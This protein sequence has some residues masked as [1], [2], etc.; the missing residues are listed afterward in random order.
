MNK[1]NLKMAYVGVL[2]SQPSLP[3]Y[4]ST[5]KYFNKYL[6]TLGEPTAAP[7]WN[8]LSI[9]KHAENIIV[10]EKIHNGA[11]LKIDSGGFQIITGKITQN[12]ILEYIECYHLV[13]EKYHKEI[14]KIFSLDINNFTMNAD[15]ILEW[16][17]KST[18]MTIESIKKYPILKEKVLFVLQNRNRRVF[19]IWRKLFI[20]KKVWEHFELFSLGGLVGL[21]KDTKVDFNHAVPAT[22]WLLTY[23]KKY[24]FE[25]KQ[26][27]WLGQSS[28]VVF[29]AMALLEKLYGIYFTSDSSELIRF[30]PIAQ[31]LPLI[32]KIVAYN[33]KTE[34]FK[35][36]F[37]YARTGEDVLDMLSLHSWDDDNCPRATRD[38]LK[39][40][41]IDIDILNIVNQDLLDYILLVNIEWGSNLAK[42]LQDYMSLKEHK[43]KQAEH[44]AKVLKQRIK[45]DILTDLKNNKEKVKQICTSLIKIFQNVHLTQNDLRIVKYNLPDEKLAKWNLNFIEVGASEKTLPDIELQN[46][47]IYLEKLRNFKYKNQ[48][49]VIAKNIFNDSKLKRL[50]N[51]DYIELMCQHVENAM[52]VSDIITDKILE[53]KLDSWRI[54]QLKEI[55]PIMDQGKTA[56]TVYENIQWILKFEKCLLTGDTDTADNIMRDLVDSYEV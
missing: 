34:E 6:I 12:R 9:M 39:E 18:Q 8:M 23:A 24:N 22:M 37:N 54:D 1:K 11:T 27:H 14:D 35:D 52:I 26:L 5:F 56:K 28:K 2:S 44:K 51:C 19:E 16:N 41:D 10:N 17:H 40:L 15:Q 38:N 7:S 36:D 50:D 48:R 25:I 47:H 13:L 49:S 45:Q 43:T 21:K 55:H 33:D 29:I 31:K 3:A 4:R 20:D 32:Q 53:R 46:F 30:A 42:D